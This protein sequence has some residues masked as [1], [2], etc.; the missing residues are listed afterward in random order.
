MKNKSKDISYFDEPLKQLD[1]DVIWDKKRKNKLHNKIVFT[2]DND[3]SKNKTKLFAGFKYALNIGVMV[4]LL[5]FGYN[6]I[7]NSITQ[8]SGDNLTGNDGNQTIDTPIID[9]ENQ[10][11]S[12]DV[13]ENKETNI[14]IQ[15]GPS[16]T[17]IRIVEGSDLEVKVINYQI[18]PYGI[19]YLLD[20]AFAVTEVS[21]N[22]ITYSTQYDDY[23]ITLE[24]IE[25]TNLE[26]AV[27]NLQEIF[28]TENYE[29]MFELESTSVEENG[30][31]GKIQF[32]G[33]NPVKG[34]IAYE[35]GEHALAITFQYP[36]EGAD[37]MYPLLETLRKSIKV[38]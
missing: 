1:K 36:I 33:H 22:Q 28:E 7:S 35:I 9:D 3:R 15:T 8:Q 32:Y 37:A 14:E 21:N 27:T 20:E 5:F 4:I 13:V 17:V 6:F 10:V 18:Q 38:H 2:M 34:F 24:M 23:K 12:E 29:E 25:H 26:K 16:E 19:A 31:T 11:N 30:L